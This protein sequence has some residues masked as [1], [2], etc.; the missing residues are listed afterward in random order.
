MIVVKVTEALAAKTMK[1]YLAGSS[2][3]QHDRL[4]KIYPRSMRPSGQGFE[5]GLAFG[6]YV[7]LM[8]IEPEHELG[9][10]NA[11][12]SLLYAHQV[13]IVHRLILHNNK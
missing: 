2:I 10:E 11:L 4:L 3:F 9:N 7:D 5:V 13:D 1:L 12:L 8:M 6:D